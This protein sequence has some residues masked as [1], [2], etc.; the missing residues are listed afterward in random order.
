MPTRLFGK[1]PYNGNLAKFT[2]SI[3]LVTLTRQGLAPCKKHQASLGAHD[4]N[5]A[6]NTYFSSIETFAP[7][8][9]RCLGRG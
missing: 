6:G 8:I 2:M 4:V 5:L 7:S 1:N 3:W 9:R